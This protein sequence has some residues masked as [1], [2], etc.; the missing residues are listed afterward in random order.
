[1]A[2][3]YDLIVIGSGTA[4]SVT[5]GKC[6]EAGWS[7]AMIDELPFGGTCAL[8]GCDPKKV[9]VGVT[10]YLDG[11][12]RLEGFGLAGDTRISWRGLMQFKRTFTEDV[13]ERRVKSFNERGID[14]YHGHAAFI[15]E[16]TLQ[17]NDETLQ[18]K[19]ILIATGASP[20]RL[21]IEGSEHFTYSDEFLEL[22][23]LPAN[24]LFVGG[25]YISFEFAHIAR[26]AGANVRILHRGDQPLAGFDSDLVSR[27]VD[28]SREIGIDLQL[29]TDVKEIQQ[30]A[31]SF[32][33]IGQQGDE[34]KAFE[35]GLVIH[36]AGRTPN[37][38][39]L[40]L[41]QAN[42]NAGRKG[43]DV[44]EFLQSTSNPNVYAAGDVAATQG[45]P[46]TPVAGMESHIVCSNMLKGN[47]RTAAG[48]VMPTS[49]FTLPKL[50][51]VGLSEMEADEKG[52]DYKVNAMELTDWFTYKRTRQPVAYAKI[53]ID[54]EKDR[55][56]GAHLLGH[57]ADE[58]INHFATAI[59][60]DIPTG[61]LKRM[62]FAYPTAASD[63]TYML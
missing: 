46:L 1:M 10:E 48:Q 41:E 39:S 51:S 37:I 55:I 34:T 33:V 57:E 42:I 20:A 44:N 11:V 29:G 30:T 31:D 5:A 49:V 22:D 59:Q 15:A 13:P 63:I 6:R 47:H 60:F 8:R 36:G 4:G 61:D 21:P 28:Y 26:R 7:V 52:I 25:G 14:T 35:A 50:A 32:S 54:Q 45:K 27:L 3:E 58:L 40:D 18:G 62:L 19:K 9:M 43:I 17:V 12:E 24:I 56:V 53:L 23:E 38:A 2:K 16:D